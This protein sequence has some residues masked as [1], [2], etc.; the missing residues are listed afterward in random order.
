MIPRESV[1]R[2]QILKGVLDIC[3][4][5]VVSGSPAYGYEMTRRLAAQGLDL[6]GESSIYPALARLERH[7]F[8]ETF[9]RPSNDGPTRKYYRVTEDGATALLRWREEW[10]CMRTAVDGVLDETHEELVDAD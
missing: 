7:G 6:V 1:R 3:L 8:V 9:R 10:R 2:S 4:L 5:A